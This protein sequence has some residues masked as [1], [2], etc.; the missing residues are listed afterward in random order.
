MRFEKVTFGQFFQDFQDCCGQSMFA[1]E[2]DVIRDI[3]DQIR[4]PERSTAFPPG[5]TFLLHAG[6]I[7]Q[8]SL[9]W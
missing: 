1:S 2:D 7:F 3:Y 6:S 8:G 4:I 9:R 5:M